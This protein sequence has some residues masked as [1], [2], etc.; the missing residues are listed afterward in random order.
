VIT[1]AAS[2]PKIPGML[3]QVAENDGNSFIFKVIS[4]TP[5][6]D[7]EWESA[8]TA[9]TRE[10]L[11]RKQAAAWIDFVRDLRAKSYILVNTAMLGGHP[12]MP[13]GRTTIAPRM[14]HW[15]YEYIGRRPSSNSDR[16]A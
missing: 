8:K 6:S 12:D 2:L 7:Q 4:R 13:N 3:D 10:L 1:A 15:A 11:Q 5:P 9:F 14:R 16:H